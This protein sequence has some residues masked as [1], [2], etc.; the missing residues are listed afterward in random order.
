[1]IVAELRR[2]DVKTIEQTPLVTEK[3][4]QSAYSDRKVAEDYIKI[5]FTSEL[6]RLLHQRQVSAVQRVLSQLGDAP[7]LEIAPGPGRLTRELKPKGSLVC[8]EYNEAMI[9]AGRPCCSSQTRWVRG[10]AFQLPFAQ[11][12]GLVYTFRFIRHFRKDDRERLYREIHRVL[13]P[14]GL[15]LMDAVNVRVSAP[16]R[17][18]HPE[19]YP[20]HDELYNADQ[21]REELRQAGFETLDL[22]PVQ[23]WFR[24][25]WRSQVYIGPR[26]NWLN[27]LIIRGLE[28]L[29]RREGLEWIV[30]CRRA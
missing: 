5:R 18:A 28:A 29:P 11:E 25:Q 23:K 27:R 9:E 16:L 15:F 14:G 8:L 1:M 20:I 24:W 21:L 7:I 2:L 26:A 30:T 6:H 17:I 4:I 19:A 22:E 12:F 13:K 10:N 3:E